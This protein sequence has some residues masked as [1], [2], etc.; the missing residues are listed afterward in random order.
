MKRKFCRFRVLERCL[1]S[2][3]RGRLE[4]GAGRWDDEEETAGPTVLDASW[5]E[6]WVR[7]SGAGK[8]ICYWVRR[9]VEGPAEV[10]IGRRDGPPVRQGPPH[11]HV[12]GNNVYRDWGHPEGPSSVPA[13][14]IRGRRVY[15]GEGAPAGAT[16]V[17]EYLIEPWSQ[18]GRGV[19]IRR[20]ID[21]E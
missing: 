13:L 1:I 19:R 7:R 17:A 16:N 2:W 21:L 14:L 4:S 3:W 10:Y 18:S 8:H 12:N 6:R 15:A 11:F 20:V 9:P 5:T